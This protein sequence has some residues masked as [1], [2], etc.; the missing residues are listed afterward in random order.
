MDFAANL[1]MESKNDWTQDELIKVGQKLK[2]LRISKGYSNYENFAYDH[3]LARAQYGRYEKG[4]DM[5]L[6]SLLKVLKTL[7]I[8]PAKFFEQL[9]S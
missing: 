8:S 6:S 1:G 2:E 9:E 7:D 3:D 4:Q 5:R